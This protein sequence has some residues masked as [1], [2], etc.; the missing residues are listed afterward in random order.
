MGRGWIDSY[1]ISYVIQPASPLRFALLRRCACG[2]LV[3]WDCCFFKIAAPSL[4]GLSLTLSLTKICYVCVGSAAIF[5]AID[6]VQT[7]VC[8]CSSCLMPFVLAF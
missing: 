7:Q 1:A 3:L 8:T 5:V 4:L 2:L 6:T